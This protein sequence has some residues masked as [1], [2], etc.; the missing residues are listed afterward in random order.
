MYKTIA[1]FRDL[2]DNGHTYRPGD[3][4]PRGGLTVNAARIAELS[5]NDN[6]RG[7]PLIEAVETPVQAVEAKGEEIP[8]EAAKTA[9]RPSRSRKKG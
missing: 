2:Q 6:A 5:G 4:F 7:Y 8:A 3:T 9:A 1:F